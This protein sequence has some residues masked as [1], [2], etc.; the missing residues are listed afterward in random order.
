MRETAELKYKN[1]TKSSALVAKI[2]ERLIQMGPAS[3]SNQELLEVIINTETRGKNIVY[4][5][6]KLLKYLGMKKEIPSS[7]REICSLLGA[8]LDK[9]CVVAAMLE[10]GR[11]YW[12]PTGT[13]IQN[14][15]DVYSLLRHYAYC[16]QEQFICLSLNILNEL[17]ALRVVSIGILNRTIVHPREVFADPIVDRASSVIVAHNHPS[18]RVEPSPEDDEI[19]SVLQSAAGLLGIRVLDHII[20]TKDSWFS[21]RKSGRMDNQSVHN[22][23]AS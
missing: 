20:F 16:K 1:K 22:S 19:T 12:G 13:K 6:K 3:L 5:T 18:G 17:L 14:P 11:R 10:F 23:M 7:I 8:G 4:K 9:A 15:Q 2:R 21:Y